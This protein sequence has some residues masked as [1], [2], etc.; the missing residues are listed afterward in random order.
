MQHN[1][2]TLIRSGARSGTRVAHPVCGPLARATVDSGF[3]RAKRLFGLRTYGLLAIPAFTLADEL[4]H[5]LAAVQAYIGFKHVAEAAPTVFA[6]GW[7]AY[8]CVIVVR[9]AERRPVHDALSKLPLE[10]RLQVLEDLLVRRKSYAAIL[11]PL[12]AK[13]LEL[14]PIELLHAP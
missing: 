1:L 2:K 4:T 13:D 14:Q 12:E 8:T 10:R 9:R 7:L 6:L 3:E 11:K 5:R